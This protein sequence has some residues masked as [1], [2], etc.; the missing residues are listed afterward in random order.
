LKKDEELKEDEKRRKIKSISPSSSTTIKKKKEGVI[1]RIQNKQPTT[2]INTNLVIFTC[3]R[4][5]CIFRVKQVSRKTLG[6]D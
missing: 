5:L 4:K 3:L 2:V 6:K 1:W